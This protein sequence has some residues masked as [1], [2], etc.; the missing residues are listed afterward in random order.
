MVMV[1]ALTCDAMRCDPPP[2]P[3]MTSQRSSEIYWHPS[4]FWRE[5]KNTAL[6]G[7]PERGW[8]VLVAAHSTQEIF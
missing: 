4:Y 6:R 3:E 2:S 8:R 7:E 1:L 5:E